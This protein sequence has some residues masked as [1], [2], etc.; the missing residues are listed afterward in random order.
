MMRSRTSRAELH[1]EWREQTA[2]RPRAIERGEAGVEADR[3]SIR[4]RSQGR[5]SRNRLLWLGRY[6]GIYVWHLTH[7]VMASQLPRASSDLLLTQSKFQHL[8]LECV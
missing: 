8:A 2:K 5:G 6:L 4:H 1:V 7:F 3:G